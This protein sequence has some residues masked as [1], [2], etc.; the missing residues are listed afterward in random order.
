MRKICKKPGP[1][2][3]NS[4]IIVLKEVC[5][6][7]KLTNGTEVKTFASPNQAIRE[8]TGYVGTG[9]NTAACLRDLAAAGWEVVERTESNR[10]VRSREERL[11]ADFLK[12]INYFKEVDKSALEEM[13]KKKKMLF[14]KEDLDETDLAEIR[15]INSEIKRIMNPTI[16]K[17]TI[18]EE[19]SKLCDLYLD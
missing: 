15:K 10:T 8:L 14:N 19:V 9:K 11:K 6:M 4:G 5:R 16:T 18:L 7:I 3:G 12:L 17:E 1:E 13:E 2:T